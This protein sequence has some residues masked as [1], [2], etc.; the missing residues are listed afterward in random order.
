MLC[1]RILVNYAIGN[2]TCLD[3]IDEK[4][5]AQG[6]AFTSLS[7]NRHASEETRSWQAKRDRKRKKEE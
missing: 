1:K 4:L 3:M 6:R 7:L 2:R 5:P